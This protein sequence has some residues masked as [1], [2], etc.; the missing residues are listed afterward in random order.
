MVRKVKTPELPEEVKYYTCWKPYPNN[1]DF[2]DP[3][4][5]IKFCRWIA[6]MLGGSSP[7]FAVYYKPKS[8]GMVIF[9]VDKEFPHPERLLGEHRYSE[10]LKKPDKNEGRLVSQIFYCAYNTER[11][12]Q[13]YGWKC[14]NVEEFF[15]A[16]YGIDK[17][18]TK[19]P[20]PAPHWCQTPSENI[21]DRALCRPLPGSQ[22]PKPLE[23][24]A[25]APPRPVVG[26]SAWT[27]RR[28]SNPQRN[29]PTS[30][31]GRGRANGANSQ[32]KQIPRASKGAGPQPGTSSQTLFP[33]L[34]PATPAPKSSRTPLSAPPA[35]NGRSVWEN[36]PSNVKSATT[37]TATLA[38]P[39]VHPVWTTKRSKFQTSPAG[40]TSSASPS[41]PSTVQS[42]SGKN[43]PTS[44]AQSAKGGPSKVANKNDSHS[45]GT[46]D[47]SPVPEIPRKSGGSSCSSMQSGGSSP[48]SA[49]SSAPSSPL[50]TSSA[51][52][53]APVLL[54]LTEYDY[55]NDFDEEITEE[56][57]QET[58]ETA[59]TYKLFEVSVP[60]V[61]VGKSKKGK[62][63]ETTYYHPFVAAV[64]EAET[65]KT[66][67][68]NLWADITPIVRS[69][70]SMTA[71]EAHAK[72]GRELICPVHKGKCK[73]GIC[74]EYKELKRQEKRKKKKEGRIERK[75]QEKEAEE[76]E[77]EKAGK[78]D[79]SSKDTSGAAA[80]AIENASEG[81][82]Q[83][84]KDAAKSNK[85][86]KP[87]QSKPWDEYPSDDD[88]LGDLPSVMPRGKSNSRKYYDDEEYY[89]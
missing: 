71:A 20:Y 51:L 64:E 77:D 75:I 79:G 25:P 55:E 65:E 21:T 58:C 70:G 46:L 22:V 26:S 16:N 86:G 87:F 59:T 89:D 48:P 52:P 31:I 40:N 9:S 69:T 62:Q 39:S 81:R 30:G 57:Y 29:P 27:E 13:K 44:Q 47:R 10:F 37:G 28:S 8:R 33:P 60:T 14:I 19:V 76:E 24:A 82:Q 45:R 80:S 78:D 18:F 66:E 15:F 43:S 53:Q 3:S 11:E 1:A 4:D 5:Y 2:E 7:L 41:G 73:R 84:T 42:A 32:Q 35:A 72:E 74:E 23:V 49:V 85:S 17:W 88:D 6:N 12:V 68:T 67:T 36:K 50:P 54:D 63:K 61:R 38:S 83:T 56:T 34:G